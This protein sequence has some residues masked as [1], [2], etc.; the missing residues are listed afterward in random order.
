MHTIFCFSLYKG[1]YKTVRT[2]FIMRLSLQ[3]Y[4]YIMVII[5]LYFIYVIVLPDFQSDNV[6]SHYKNI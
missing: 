2:L 6:K 3:F 4:K 5:L 1:N